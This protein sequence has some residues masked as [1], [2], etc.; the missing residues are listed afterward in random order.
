MQ[1]Q[2]A[3]TNE[4]QTLDARGFDHDAAVLAYQKLITE[5]PPL[6]RQLLLYILDL[7]AVFA[8]KSEL[9]KMN[10]AN[11]S[12]IFQPGLISHPSHDMAPAE[13][14]LSQYV[15]IFLIE[16]QDNFLIGMSGTA[17]DEKTV[18]EVQSGAI[19]ISV[20]KTTTLGRS[21]SNASAGADSL[22]KYGGVRR[23][24]STSSRTSKASGSN[25]APSTPNSGVGFSGAS[26]GGLGRSN[27]VPSK[28]SPGLASA[29]FP[30]PSEPSTPNSATL[31]PQAAYSRTN[32]GPTSPLASSTNVTPAPTSSTPQLMS[33]ETSDSLTPIA[34]PLPAHAN[35]DRIERAD[36]ASP[37]PSPKLGPTT[38]PAKERKIS[39]LF[40][41]SPS[42]DAEKKDLKPP[43][44]LRKKRIGSGISSAQSS[45]HSLGLPDGYISPAYTTPL[46]S[47]EIGRSN[48]MDSI[49]LS[50]NPATPQT[51]EEDPMAAKF[52][53]AA[54]YP[55]GTSTLRPRAKSPAPSNHSRSSV[56]DHSDFDLNDTPN[57]RAE[58]N[59]RRWRFSHQG[60]ENPEMG[61]HAM[62]QYSTSSVGSSSRPR[63]S[64]TNDS[65]QIGTD[66]SSN[67]AGVPALPNAGT[68]L[69][70]NSMEPERK[71]IFGKLKAKM[72]QSRDRAKS[73]PRSDN[74]GGKSKQ[75]LN[76]IIAE[77][78]TSPE[79]PTAGAEGPSEATADAHPTTT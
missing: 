74:E 3:E 71:G 34:A 26:S 33:S 18:K 62:A 55:S 4:L 13:Y 43:N 50:V 53:P 24:L 78:V 46:V 35:L 61:T 16:N 42:S 41:K 14:K 21:A 38:T 30:R 76:A 10:S 68:D 31:T 12:A 29:R 79:K 58:K 44:K 59:R 47:P 77:G 64:F 15:L 48:P 60:K 17:A 39:G 36:R 66:V 1:A 65:Q 51:I 28:K 20:P 8:S 52:E 23:N 63:K 19:P 7:L 6:N 75:S 45:T 72:T 9:N 2:A 37:S 11:L 54:Q 40:G 32:T 70:D 49:P 67:S 27:T 56:T 25:Q 22:R 57:G 5:L 69:K 73:P